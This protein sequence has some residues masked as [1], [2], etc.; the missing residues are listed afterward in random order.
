MAPNVTNVAI[1][2]SKIVIYGTGVSSI[3]IISMLQKKN[4]KIFS[5]S[6]LQQYKEGGLTY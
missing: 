4:N 2:N 6:T 5:I 1:N 3:D